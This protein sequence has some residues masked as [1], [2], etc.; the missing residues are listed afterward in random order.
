MKQNDN[1]G[2]KCKSCGKVTFPKRAVCLKC[3]KRDFETVSMDGNVTLLTFTN[4]YQLP[5]GIND[6]YLTLGVCQFDNGLKAS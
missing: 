2:Y 6:R 5:W 1:K 4:V 3:G